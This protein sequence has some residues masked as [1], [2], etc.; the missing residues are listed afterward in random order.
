MVTTHVTNASTTVDWTDRLAH[1]LRNAQESPI[2]A[3]NA[4]I[5]NIPGILKLTLGEPDFPTPEHI[6][7]A[8]V[9]ALANGRTHY[10]PS[11]GTPG[12]REAIVTYLDRRMGLSYEPSQIIVTEGAYEALSSVLHALL[13]PGSTLIVPSPYFGLYENLGVLN[14]AQFVPID[15]SDTDF[16]LSPEQLDEVARSHHDSRI[17][18]LLNDPCNP[19]GVAYPA[20]LIERIAQVAVKHDMIVVSDEVYAQITYDVAHTSIARYIPER[21]LVIDSA[22]KTYAMTGWRL[23]YIA[24]PVAVA[25]QIAKSHQLAVGSAAMMVMDAAEEAY[26]NGDSDIDRMATEYRHRRDL[27]SGLLAEAGYD[28][29][30]PGGAFYLYV[31]IPDDYQESSTQYATDMAHQALVAGV[32]G[33]AFEPTPSRYVRFSYAASVDQLREA[34]KRISEWHNSGTAPQINTSV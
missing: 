33:D 29:V 19:T 14:D 9:R 5:S 8:A 2:R 6:T 28:F 1:G 11:S 30:T 15:T 3:F 31:R 23:G 20:Q 22:S 21:T 10:A 24:A 17:V 34:A 4:R 12:L 32:P 18:L 26:R 25:S 27:F 13:G 16:L 7:Q